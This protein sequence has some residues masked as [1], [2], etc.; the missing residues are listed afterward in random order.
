M[1]GSARAFNPW[2]LDRGR[3]GEFHSPADAEKPPEGLETLNTAIFGGGATITVEESP[4]GRR[5]I[6]L[7]YDPLMMFGMLKSFKL[8]VTGGEIVSSNA[9][10]VEE[11][12]AIWNDLDY[13]AEVVLTEASSGSAV[14]TGTIIPA[15]VLMGMVLPFAWKRREAWL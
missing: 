3:A 10:R 14:C 8:S 6:H 9:D 7:S 13:G 12:T 4:E 11:N 15:V 2:R 5:Q 1:S